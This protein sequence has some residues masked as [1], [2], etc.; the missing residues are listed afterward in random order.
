MIKYDNKQIENNLNDKNADIENI[1]NIEN[2]KFKN[3]EKERLEYILKF[4][5][6]GTPEDAASLAERLIEKYGSIYNISNT[7]KLELIKTKGM[8]ERLA[9]F[10]TT[11]QNCFQLY[12]LSRINEFQY[13]D[14]RDKIL[15]YLG[16]SIKYL[17][18]EEAIIVGLRKNNK[19]IKTKFFRGE[20]FE[21]NLT[22]RQVIKF[23]CET[24]ASKIVLLHNHPSGKKSPSINDIIQTKNIMITLK[25]LKI[26]LIDH[27]IVTSKD[28]YSFE[29]NGILDVIN[30]IKFREKSKYSL[31]LNNPNI[32]M[33]LMAK[34][35]ELNKFNLSDDEKLIIAACDF[36]FSLNEK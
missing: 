20:E 33:G 5:V 10:F 25:A 3:S 9:I 21:V 7:N 18:H 32:R 24:K 28:Y 36:V 27:L 26:P 34:T 13:L 30:T 8:T 15:E 11:L 14:S 2:K 31:L 29:E 19:L 6:K 35:L 1:F 16:T 22:V 12:Q 4:I 23:I 17:N